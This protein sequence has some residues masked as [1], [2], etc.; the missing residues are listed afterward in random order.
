MKYKI[1]KYYLNPKSLHIALVLVLIAHF[2]IP[3]FL[4]LDFKQPFEIGLMCI[5]IVLFIWSCF[6]FFVQTYDSDDI[7]EIIKELEVE[8]ANTLKYN[9]DYE[10]EDKIVFYNELHNLIKDNDFYIHALKNRFEYTSM[11]NIM[12]YLLIFFILFIGQ[13]SF[14]YLNPIGP[15]ILIVLLTSLILFFLFILIW[16]FSRIKALVSNIIFG[17]VF[18]IYVFFSWDKNCYVRNF[19]DE[20]IGSYFEKSEYITKYYVNVFENQDRA[21]NYRLPA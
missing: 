7:D 18:F 12:N 13:N 6:Y 3:Q 2:S 4:S 20:I 10:K 5:Y 16:E 1:S 14:N 19:G 21:K 11:E 8:K 9:D 15:I 17:H